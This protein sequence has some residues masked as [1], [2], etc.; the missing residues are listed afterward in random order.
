M[1]ASK[2]HNSGKGHI[3]DVKK[4]C[5]SYFFMKNPYKKFQNPSIHGQV[6]YKKLLICHLT[7]FISYVMH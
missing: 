6:A 2:G 4:K 1:S 7:R 5:T 3:L